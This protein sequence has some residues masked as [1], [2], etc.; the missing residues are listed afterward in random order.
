MLIGMPRQM[1]RSRRT[2]R[3]R[4]NNAARA[5]R[6]S[7]SVIS[8]ARFSGAGLAA[9][10][11]ALLEEDPPP[12]SHG[13]R[14]RRSETRCASGGT[15]LSS[16]TITLDRSMSCRQSKSIIPARTA[17]ALTPTLSI[18]FAF[19]FENPRAFSPSLP[20]VHVTLVAAHRRLPMRFPSRPALNT[21][22]IRV[23][24]L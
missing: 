5:A 16:P 12:N 10:V 23:L 1:K 17:S 15:S 18:V 24:R 9:G 2:Q 6:Y 21:S 3:R 4:R 22:S 19:P 7:S 20:L 13:F 8:V 11:P 14:R